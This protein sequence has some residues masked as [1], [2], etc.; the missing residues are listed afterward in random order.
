MKYLTAALF[1]F[2]AYYVVPSVM[3][4]AEGAPEVAALGDIGRALN[5]AVGLIGSFVVAV[6]IAAVVLSPIRPKTGS[7]PV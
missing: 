7:R 2:V 4:G 3:R 5:V 1:P 6:T